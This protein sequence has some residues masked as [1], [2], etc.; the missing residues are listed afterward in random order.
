MKYSKPRLEVLETRHLLSV[1]LVV[2]FNL[3]PQ[4]GA[5]SHLTEFQDQVFFF[6]QGNRD[7]VELWKTGGEPDNTE[8]VAELPPTAQGNVRPPIAPLVHGSEMFFILGDQLYKSDGTEVVSVSAGGNLGSVTEDASWLVLDDTIFLWT[9]D[10]QRLLAMDGNGDLQLLYSP[11]ASS[12]SGQYRSSPIVAFQDEVYFSVRQGSQADLW[13]SDGTTAGTVKVAD[14]RGETTLAGVAGDALIIHNVAT[15]WAVDGTSVTSLFSEAN[16]R[17]ISP[18]ID[19][20][21]YFSGLSLEHGI[22]VWRTNGQDVE[23]FADIVPGPASSHPTRLQSFGDGFL[24]DAQSGVDFGEAF[25][26]TDGTRDATDLIFEGRRVDCCGFSSRV[27]GDEFYFFASDLQAWKTDGSIAGTQPVPDDSPLARRSTTGEAVQL[28]ART[29]FNGYSD[30]VGQEIWST[31]GEQFWLLADTRTGTL[32]S[33]PLLEANGDDLWVSQVPLGDGSTPAAGLTRISAG[34]VTSLVGP[35]YGI[36]EVVPSNDG[37]QVFVLRGDEGVHDLYLVTGDQLRHLHGARIES[38]TPLGDRRLAFT[39]VDHG[40]DTVD[41][42]VSDGTVEGTEKVADSIDDIPYQQVGVVAVGQETLFFLRESRERG[43]ELWKVTLGQPPQLVKQ[44]HSER[45]VHFM[46]LFASGDRVLATIG[47]RTSSMERSFPVWASD[48]T[49][50]GTQLVF[51]TDR[52]L[53]SQILQVNGSALFETLV[54][55]EP[56]IFRVANTSEGQVVQ[57]LAS[58]SIWEQWFPFEPGLASTIGDVAVVGTSRGYFVAFTDEFGREIWTTDGTPAGTRLVRDLA[59]GPEH[60][61]FPSA[62][63]ID[64]DQLYFTAIEPNGG[65]V[66]MWTSDG[67]Q[68]GT[69]RI[70]AD[71]PRSISQLTPVGDTLFFTADDALVGEEVFSIAIP[72]R[73]LVGDLDA[74]GVVDYEDFLILASNFGRELARPTAGDVD[75]DQSVGFADFLILAANFGNAL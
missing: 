19:G 42:W 4:S 69:Y 12:E 47:D 14:F 11:V 52:R 57:N 68:E 29:I 3:A 17:L 71:L 23:L 6:A 53:R 24:V 9:P 5:P 73:P 16:T 43:T 18:V 21:V 32:G 59:P 72:E 63:G 41:V 50:A 62:L 58:V 55:G 75:G 65:G 37:Q 61:Y 20:Y 1:D 56:G 31:E 10:T 66:E 30:E 49:A 7:T 38:Y 35:D 46:R 2:D 70:A 40:N 45:G 34:K 36:Y 48:G 28:G 15:I 27:V 33:R 22:E 44:L 8:V 54:D 13:R 26:F 25:W 67:S 64:G 39:T 60:T 74:N 51:R